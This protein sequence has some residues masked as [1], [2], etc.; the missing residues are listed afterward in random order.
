M[1]Y[2]FDRDLVGGARKHPVS[3]CAERGCHEMFT[4]ATCPEHES[5]LCPRC[6]RCEYCGKEYEA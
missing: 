6:G 5:D 4:P 1:K 3:E 2:L